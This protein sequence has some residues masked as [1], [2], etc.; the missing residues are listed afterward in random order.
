MGKPN[1]FQIATKELSQDGFFTWLLQWADNRNAQY[2]QELHETAQNFIRFLLDK[3]AD[4]QITKVEAVRQR[5]NID[6]WAEVNDNILIIIEDKTNT[7][8]HSDQLSRYKEI[9]QKWCDKNKR[10]LVCLYLKTGSEAKS[11]LKK[12]SKNGYMIIDRTKLLSFFNNYYIQ[13]DI[14]TDLVE[15]L[16]KIEKSVS[17]YKTL[18]IAKWKWASWEGFYQLLDEKL[19]INDWR[20]VSNPNGGFLG[21]WW[22]FHD[23]KDYCVYLQIEQGNLCFKIG[24]VEENHSKSRNEWY[25]I[26]MKQAKKEGKKEIQKPARFGNGIYMTVAIVSQKDWLGADDSIFDESKVIE[27]L[28]EYERFFSRCLE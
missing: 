24:N 25:E 21:L 19:R 14:Y 9:A 10:Q 28:K 27:Q 1:I 22:H 17:S 4:F 13:N 3:T 12:V 2:N 15:K 23:W 18:P 26:I 5:E 7:G 20:Y 16:N 6:I 11:S 8:E